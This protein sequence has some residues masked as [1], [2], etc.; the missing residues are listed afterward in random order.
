MA[1]RKSTDEHFCAFMKTFKKSPIF[2]QL[3]STCHSS[4][5]LASF[6]KTATK[7]TSLHDQ[8]VYSVVAPN[9]GNIKWK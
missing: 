5:L 6:T 9:K 2:S 3:Q 8:H 7:G 1:F 4:S